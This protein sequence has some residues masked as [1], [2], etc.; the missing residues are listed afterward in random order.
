MKLAPNQRAEAVGVVEVDT[1]EVDTEAVLAGTAVVAGVDGGIEEGSS[2]IKTTTTKATYR[3]VNI[4]VFSD[5]QGRGTIYSCTNDTGRQKTLVQWFA[6]QGEA[7]A[8]E[9]REIDAVLTAR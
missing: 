6:T 1:V 2:M 8:N 9:R 3:G 4:A 5:N 7:I